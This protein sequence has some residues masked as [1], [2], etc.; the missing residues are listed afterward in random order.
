MAGRH[1]FISAD[2]CVMCAQVA[3]YRAER[4]TYS[5]LDG[6]TCPRCQKVEELAAAREAGEEVAQIAKA[7]AEGVQRGLR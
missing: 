4:P 3:A 2:H 7:Y 1:E 5:H 6:C